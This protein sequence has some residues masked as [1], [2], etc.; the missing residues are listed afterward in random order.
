MYYLNPIYY[1]DNLQSKFSQAKIREFP[2][3]ARARAGWGKRN[4]LFFSLV[5]LSRERI[6]RTGG[7]GVL[8]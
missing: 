6:Q 8:L 1:N 5:S 2:I 7:G 4:L 3:V